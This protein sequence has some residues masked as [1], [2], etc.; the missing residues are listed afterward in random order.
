MELL[1]AAARGQGVLPD[2]MGRA[3]L[4]VHPTAGSRA[5]FQDTHQTVS[6]SGS[7]QAGHGPPP[8]C[9]QPSHMVRAHSS[10]CFCYCG[11]P[12][13]SLFLLSCKFT[14]ATVF[15]KSLQLKFNVKVARGLVFQL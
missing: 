11:P 7:T 5:G 3:I 15:L 8:R 6:R 9:L 1:L 4:R 10:G 14:A 2:S 12:P 13:M